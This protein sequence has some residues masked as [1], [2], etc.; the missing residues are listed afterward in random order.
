MNLEFEFSRLTLNPPFHKLRLLSFE[1]I[2]AY[3][4]VNQN[5][6]IGIKIS[7]RQSNNL[8]FGFIYF[9]VNPFNVNLLPKREAD[10]LLIDLF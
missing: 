3:F 2:K 9:H 7:W 5:I 10:A 1:N 4:D 6:I 8:E